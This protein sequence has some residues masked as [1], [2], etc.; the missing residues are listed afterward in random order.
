MTIIDW[1]MWSISF[2]VVLCNHRCSFTSSFS[3]RK[4]CLIEHFLWKIR[5]ILTIWTGESRKSF[6][7][8]FI[9]DFFSESNSFVRQDQSMLECRLE[10][11]AF[12]SWIEAKLNDLR[13]TLQR[14][15]LDEQKIE[16]KEK[17]I[18][19]KFQVFFSFRFNRSNRRRS[20]FLLKDFFQTLID[21]ENKENQILQ[22]QIETIFNETIRLNRLL[23]LDETIEVN[24]KQQ[25]RFLFI[26][27]RKKNLFI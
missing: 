3:F 26:S 17:S 6:F 1:S 16:E 18:V 10:H 21:I 5:R 25:N 13:T 8:K 19:E 9:E 7:L 12:Y 22:S 4:K 11:V 27:T 14:R 23:K 2:F 15:G 20:S 24:S